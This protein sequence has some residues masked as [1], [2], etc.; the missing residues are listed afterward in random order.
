MPVLASDYQSGHAD[1]LDERLGMADLRSWEFQAEW[2][3]IGIDGDTWS[4]S[5]DP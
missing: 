4:T 2:R 3:G 5:V 1:F